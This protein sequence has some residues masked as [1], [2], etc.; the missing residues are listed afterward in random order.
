MRAMLLNIA[1]FQVVWFALILIGDLAII[2]AIG[3]CVWHVLRVAEPLE[4]KYMVLWGVIGL[5]I[6]QILSFVGVLRFPEMSLPVLPLWFVG[7]W[8][9]FP[10]VLNHSLRWVWNGH[11]IWTV[12]GAMG[13]ALTYLGGA[14]LAPVE[15]PLGDLTTFA[16][17]TVTWLFF[18][19]LVRRSVPRA[20]T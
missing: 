15:L 14:R 9:V 19:N 6:D 2:A 7:L 3:W 10:T 12:L 1:G 16:I 8:I 20:T 11:P 17:L 5:A 13:A 4:P 18:F